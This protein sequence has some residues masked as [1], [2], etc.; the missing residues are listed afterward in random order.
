MRLV[1]EIDAGGTAVLIARLDPLPS[2]DGDIEIDL[3]EVDF[4]GSSGLRALIDAHQRAERYGR[5]VVMAQPSTTVS[6]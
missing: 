6:P 5:H 4:I 1:G 2:I 3:S